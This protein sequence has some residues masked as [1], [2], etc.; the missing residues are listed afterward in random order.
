MNYISKIQITLYIHMTKVIYI[1]Y[2]TTT[3]TTATTTT[4]RWGGSLLQ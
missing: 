4:L 2:I 3:M 1:I